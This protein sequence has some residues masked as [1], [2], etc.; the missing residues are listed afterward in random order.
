MVSPIW[1]KP[2]SRPSWPIA[3]ELNEID[4]TAAEKPADEE[5]SW[6]HV[7]LALLGGAVAAAS[8]ARFLFV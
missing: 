3:G 4:L 6:L 5:R 2:V 7:V 8:T 1:C